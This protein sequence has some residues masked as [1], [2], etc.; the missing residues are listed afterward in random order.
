M[1]LVHLNVES[2]KYFD[3][4]VDFL[5]T[6]KPDILSL[7]EATNGSFLGSQG[8]EQR[9]YLG[10][11]YQKFGWNFIFHP[12][13]FRDFGSYEIGFGAAVL[14]RFPITLEDKQ[15]FGEQRPTILPHDYISFSD[16]PKYERYPYAWKWSLP[17]LVTN[18]QTEQ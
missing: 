2:F 3:A 12:T 14:S 7:V 5:E 15:Y 8:G 9:D 6:E 13:V 17:F 11:L 10:E 16:K 18:I 1:K 4:L